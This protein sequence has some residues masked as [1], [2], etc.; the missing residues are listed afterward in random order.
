MKSAVDPNSLLV[1]VLFKF[2]FI[3]LILIMIL[4]INDSL[5]FKKMC[6]LLTGTKTYRRR[7]HFAVYHHR[8]AVRPA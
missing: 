2:K 6:I 4:M 5:L 8:S 7:A 1:L 3:Y